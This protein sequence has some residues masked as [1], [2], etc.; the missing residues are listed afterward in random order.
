MRLVQPSRLGALQVAKSEHQ[1]SL[2]TQG[3]KSGG[4]PREA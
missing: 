1:N 4:I 2:K 3:K